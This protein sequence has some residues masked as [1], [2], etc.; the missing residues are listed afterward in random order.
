[1]Q[2][3]LFLA[4]LFL[5]ILIH[6]QLKPIDSSKNLYDL[7]TEE[8]FKNL[9]GYKVQSMQRLDSK[10]SRGFPGVYIFKDGN[11]VEV[12]E[13]NEYIFYFSKN[14]YKIDDVIFNGK[15]VTFFLS[16][17]DQKVKWD[18]SSLMM[19]ERPFILTAY[20]NYIHNFFKKDKIIYADYDGQVNDKN[21]YDVGN[22]IIYEPVF[23]GYKSIGNNPR[24]EKAIIELK[25]IKYGTNKIILFDDFKPKLA[26]DYSLYE[27][28]LKNKS[29][30]DLDRKSKILKKY[31]AKT[32][33]KII[34]GDVWIGMSREMLIESKGRPT[35][36]GLTTETKTTISSQYIYES[37]LF[38][39][40]FIYLEN[41]KVV[42]I[43]NL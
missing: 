14:E 41:G 22:D 10:D 32:G 21:I 1:M 31:G 18:K 11:Y 16:N 40:E 24:F 33:Q 37:K 4:Y 19:T 34:D 28:A 26:F 27:S 38:G 42:A 43:Q 2:K 25:S 3:L 8:E 29:Q 35:R 30:S 7:K 23:V 13:K 20:S 5:G 15:S 39:T 9:I 17:N 12:K 36:I 6:S